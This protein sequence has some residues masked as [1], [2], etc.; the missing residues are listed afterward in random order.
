MPTSAAPMTPPTSTEDAVERARSLFGSIRE[1]ARETDDARHVPREL[2]DAF[3]ET[4]LVRTLIPTR[5]GGTE[6][7]LLAHFDVSIEIAKAAGSMGWISSFFMAHSFF[8]AH[9]PEQAQAD[10]WNQ[11]GPD[12]LIGTSF[13]PVGRVTPA[14]GGWKL[15]GDWAWASGIEH[16]TWIMLGGVVPG[17]DGGAPEYRLFLLPTSEIE[18][19]DTWYS[20]GLRGSGSDNVVVDDVFVP[21]H[22]TMAMEGMR[23]GRSPGAEIH[24]NPLYHRP[25]MSYDGSPMVAPAIGVARGV[26]DAWQDHVRSKSHSYTQEQ[27]AAAIPMQLCLAESATQIDCADMLV[28]RALTQVESDATITLEDRVRNRRD[29]TYATRLLVKAVNELMA[30]AGAS[31]LRDDSPIQRGWRDVRAISSHVFCNFNAAG[32]NYGRM[33]FGSPLNPR[34][35]F[36]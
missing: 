28:R 3:V 11:D 32:E 2:V 6:L 12:A 33:A 7:G 19:V 34:D 14:D 17:P 31:A 29:I 18:I 10:V 4:G 21:E 26:V 27:I 15:S 24:A 20:A 8:L 13:A 22:R 25:Q 23:E 36:F 35:P 1:R 30:M 16:C 5:W 9:F